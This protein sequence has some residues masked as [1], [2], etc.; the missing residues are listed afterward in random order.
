[1]ED[2]PIVLVTGGSKRIGRAIALRVHQSGYRIAI[3]YGTSEKEARATAEECGSAPIFQ[4]DL[5]KVGEIKRMFREVEQQ[6][7]SLYGLVNN[8]ARFRRRD[9]FEITEADWDFIH[10]VNLKATFFCC[11]Q[12]ALLMK[13]TGAGRI[14]NLSSLGGIRPWDMYAHYCASKAGVIMLTRALAKAFA[15]EITVN[16][17]APGVIL[18]SSE[19]PRAQELIAATPAKR[20]GTPEEIADAV[21]HFLN[22]SNFVTGQVLAVDGGLSQR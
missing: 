18:A 20:S 17:V 15:P 22:A 7:G 16:S 2:Q 5:E 14:V 10:S 13:K 11:Q 3:H 1:M 12:G 6:L 19:D 9:A 4:A 8:A 21:L